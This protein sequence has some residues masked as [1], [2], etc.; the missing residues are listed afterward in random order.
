ME[1]GQRFT[2]L[3]DRRNG[4]WPVDA[5]RARQQRDD[6]LRALRRFDVTVREIALITGLSENYVGQITKG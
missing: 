6:A 5:T 2:T 1:C 4:D 3:E